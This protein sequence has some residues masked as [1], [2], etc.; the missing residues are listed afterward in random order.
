M[1]DRLRETRLVGRE[2]S[3][4][5]NRNF[6]KHGGKIDVGI[7][8]VASRATCRREHRLDMSFIAPRAD[9]VHFV[10]LVFERA[11]VLGVRRLAFAFRRRRRL[12]EFTLRTFRS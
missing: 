1:R 6:V 8:R 12:C 11:R 4:D 5:F 2:T 7:H 9:F 10:V 3:S